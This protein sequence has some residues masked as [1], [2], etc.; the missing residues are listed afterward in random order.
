M[1][2]ISMPEDVLEKADIWSALQRYTR[3]LPS[4][5][6]KVVPSA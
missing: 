1:I 4:V 6:V 2:K 5:I 3:D